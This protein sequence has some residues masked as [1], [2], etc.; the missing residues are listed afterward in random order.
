[1][2]DLGDFG[3]NYDDVNMRGDDNDYNDSDD[4]NNNDGKK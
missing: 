3:L 2:D 1:M 4:N